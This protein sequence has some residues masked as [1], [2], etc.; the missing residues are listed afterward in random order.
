MKRKQYA[1]T[2]KQKRP[3]N[4]GP[5]AACSLN[6]HHFCNIPRPEDKSSLSVAKGGYYLPMMLQITGFLVQERACNYK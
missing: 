6:I 3:P 1:C 5:P 2:R 4:T